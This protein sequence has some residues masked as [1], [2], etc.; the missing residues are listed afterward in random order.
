MLPAAATAQQKTAPPG[1][2]GIDEYVESV[3]AASGKR[4]TRNRA[5]P[6]GAAL[7]AAQRRELEALGDDGRVLAETIEATGPSKTE[8]VPRSGER[9]SRLAPTG[10]GDSPFTGVVEAV[11]GGSSGGM[12]I[13]LPIILAS[14]LALVMAVAVARRRATR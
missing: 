9:G 14:T 1:N 8:L 5:T 12:G 13:L 6:A 11:S 2:A 4:P 10:D 3:P 7:D